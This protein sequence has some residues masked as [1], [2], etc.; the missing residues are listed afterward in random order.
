MV[1]GK[2]VCLR[3]LSK[4]DRAREV[5]FHRFL[6]N[7]KVTTERIIESWSD[8][9]ADLRGLGRKVM[10]TQDQGMLM[11]GDNY[12]GTINFSD[13]RAFVQK[14]WNDNELLALI[15]ELLGTFDMGASNKER[16]SAQYSTAT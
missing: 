1:A 3:R 14:P 9:F 8:R 5:R 7:D 12:M 10:R 11:G 15:A 6:G 13:P 4:G 2:D 16:P